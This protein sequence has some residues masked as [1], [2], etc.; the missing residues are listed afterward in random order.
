MPTPLARSLAAILIVSSALFA[1]AC[2]GDDEQDWQGETI[3]LGSI[4]STTGDGAAFGPQ[5]VKG[6]ELAVE[7]VNGEDDGINGATLELIQKNDKGDPAT[8]AENMKS[9]IE[10]DEVMSVLGPTFSNAAAEADPIANDLKTPVLAVSNTG[11]GIVGDCP[12]PCEFI[13]RDSLAEADAIP[14]N[15]K[16]LVEAEKP[17]TAAIVHPAGDPFG[18]SSAATAKEAFRDNGVKVTADTTF[19]AG[20]DLALD[21]NPD[22]FMITASSGEAAVQLIKDLRGNGYTGPILGGNAFNSLTASAAA[23]QDGKGAQSATAWYSGNDSEENQEFIAD[24]KA[25]YNEEPD[26]FAAQAYT[27]V[28]LLAEAADDADLTFDDLTKDRE[29]IRTALEGVTEDTPLGDFKFT[30]DHDV[31]QPIWIVQM[32]GKGGFDLVKELPPE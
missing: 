29:A 28:K 17:K 12:Y 8:S 1:A 6:A 18:E 23:G 16:T 20:L 19:P 3:K 10:S 5:Q 4:F 21:S 9:L 7:D 26:Q 13:F 32:N 11:P 31:S 2:G 22:V 14:A 30:S 27:G 24:Y 25:K 15:V